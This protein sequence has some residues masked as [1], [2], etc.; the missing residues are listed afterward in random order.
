L[1]L[2]SGG[3]GAVGRP[4]DLQASGGG[5]ETSHTASVEVYSCRS[6]RSLGRLTVAHA[7]HRA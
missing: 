5:V 6:L 4:V 3:A 7:R 2:V 1:P